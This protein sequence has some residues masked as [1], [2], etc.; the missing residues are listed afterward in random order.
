MTALG[1]RGKSSA[2]L[3]KIQTHLP[4]RRRLAGQGVQGI[5][6]SEKASFSNEKSSL[7]HFLLEKNVAIKHL[8]GMVHFLLPVNLIMTD[9]AKGR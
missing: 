4:F 8:T 6:Q 9:I 3:G 5:S 7:I 1:K 2:A